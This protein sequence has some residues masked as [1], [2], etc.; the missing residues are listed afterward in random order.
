[1]QIQSEDIQLDYEVSGDGFPV[2]LLHPFPVHRGF[3]LPVARQ[4][5]AEYR[6]IAPDLR[7]HGRSGVGSGPATMAK[8]AADLSRLL[9]AERIPRAVFVGVSIGGYVLFEFWRR[10]RDRVAALVLANTRA[11]PDTEQ[12]KANRFKSIEDARLRGTTQFIESQ[13]ES[14]IGASTR[15]NRPDL[16][17]SARQMMETMTVNGLVNVQEG[18]AA[19]PDS[20]ATLS[21]I[22]VP[23][24]VIAAEEDTVTPAANANLLHSKIRDARMAVIP[25]AG[26]Y[27]AFERPKEFGRLLSQFLAGLRLVK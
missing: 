10:S 5:T 7:A 6:V 26:H 11:E 24:L 18:M 17:T 27:S 15:R 3:W 9:D 2:V 8:H 25:Q 14:L 19:R 22:D 20:V 21:T 12:G 23:T 4:L 13:L 1:V 16:V